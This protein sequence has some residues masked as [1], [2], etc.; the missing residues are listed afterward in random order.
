MELGLLSYNLLAP[1]FVGVPGQ[2][3]SFFDHVQPEHLDWGRRR[4]LIEDR[5]RSSRADLICLQ[6]VEYEAGAGDQ[7]PW[8]PPRWLAH[9]AGELDLQVVAE[10]L[11]PGDWRRRAG[12]NERKAGRAASTGLVTLVAQRHVEAGPFEVIGASRAVLVRFG[13]PEARI[14]L[15]NVHLEGHPDKG[16]ERVRQLRG[17]IDRARRGQPSHRLVVG[18]WNTPATPDTRVGR[19]LAGQ[20]GSTLVPLG[21]TY[22][23]APGHPRSTDHVLHERSLSVVEAQVVLTREDAERGMPNASSPSDHAPVFVR[24]R[25]TGAVRP[26]DEAP[27]S[28]ESSLSEEEAR[29]LASAWAALLSEAPEQPAGPPS[30]EGLAALRTFKAKKQAF[31]AGLPSEAHR[32]HVKKL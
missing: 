11:S 30:E 21:P 32:R 3:Y 12:R 2:P 25:V 8:V 5:L 23:G 17:I 27:P 14:T 22:G 20:A 18:D 31:L 6:E 7:S 29:A 10:P 1:L 4:P 24:L 28:V 13:P 26:S 9:L 16:A 19:W 15:A